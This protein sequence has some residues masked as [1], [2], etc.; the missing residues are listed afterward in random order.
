[1]ARETW[2]SI[3]YSKSFYVHTYRKGITYVLISLAINLL[4][5]VAIYY[6]HFNQ[7]ERDFYATNGIS[8]PVK[9][10]PLD[11]RNDS[12]TALLE[13]DPVNDDEPKVI[14]Q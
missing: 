7:P 6:V 12:G 2:D 14:P 5:G 8:P 10:T 3:K 4:L 11:A 9:L 1:M 13:P